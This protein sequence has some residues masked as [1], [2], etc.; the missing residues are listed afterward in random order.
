MISHH[1]NIKI[2]KE[3]FLSDR[4]AVADMLQKKWEPLNVRKIVKRFLWWKY[5]DYSVLFGHK[6]SGN[7]SSFGCTTSAPAGQPRSME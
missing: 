3:V 5:V 7:E 6:G 4:D 1:P 2:V